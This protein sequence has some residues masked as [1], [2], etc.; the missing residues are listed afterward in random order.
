MRTSGP[1][2]TSSIRDKTT[3][4]MGRERETIFPAGSSFEYETLDPKKDWNDT[5]KL[6]FEA[7]MEAD[8]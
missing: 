6:N 1:T 7:N 3:R 4:H 5:S 2:G 8:M